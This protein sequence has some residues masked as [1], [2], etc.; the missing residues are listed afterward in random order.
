MLPC[1]TRALHLFLRAEVRRRAACSPK[2]I[3]TVLTVPCIL[4]ALT[5]PITH[6]TPTLSSLSFFPAGGH[7]KGRRGG[8]RGV[9][10]GAGAAAAA[11]AAAQGGSSSG[12]S[13]GNEP[14]HAGSS[15]WRGEDGPAEEAPPRAADAAGASWA[16]S[17]QQCASS[18]EQPSIPP[19]AAALWPVPPMASPG[20]PA[21]GTFAADFQHR[22]AAAPLACK[23]A[24]CTEPSAVRL[25]CCLD[26]PVPAIIHRISPRSPILPTSAAYPTALLSAP[27]TPSA[28]S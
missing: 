8:A 22:R 3:T 17:K 25:C 27:T 19:Q 16:G 1:A 10:S 2:T 28:S 24:Q 5:V 6:Y 12:V 4:K 9:R 18:P 15:L 26:D 20:Q 14:P 11:A 23:N 21:W 13:Q 7:G